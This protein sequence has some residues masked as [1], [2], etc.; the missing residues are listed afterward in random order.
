M[1]QVIYEQNLAFWKQDYNSANAEPAMLGTGGGFGGDDC[2]TQAL[3][4]RQ[5]TFF[6]KNSKARMLQ[7]PCLLQ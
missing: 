6:C 3:F 2:G 4:T 1:A 7:M 5:Q